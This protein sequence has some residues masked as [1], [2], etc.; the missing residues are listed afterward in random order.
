MKWLIFSVGL[1]IIT[2]QAHSQSLQTVPGHCG[3]YFKNMQ[4]LRKQ[5]AS[6]MKFYNF[7]PGENVASIGAQCATWEGA[8]A[9]YTDSIHFY[10]EDIDPV[11]LNEAQVS[12]SWS[13][14]STLN[15]K[16]ITSTRKI[17]IGSESKTNLPEHY[18]DKILIINSFHEFS[19]QQG[20]LADIAG[21]LRPGGIL[22]LDETLAE[23]SGE[24][25]VQCNKRIYTGD[26][27][28]SLFKGY[29]FSYISGLDM[30]FRS[31]KIVRKI[32]AFK[33]STA[34]ES[35]HLLIDTAFHFAN[36]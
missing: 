19:D 23:K 32:F 16:T 27:L 35:A 3:L 29:G 26:E 15:K 5:L 7:H 2:G 13:Y 33:L 36:R 8:F 22:Y 12:F 17:I 31:K 24:L 11:S 18:F 1:S 14:Y 30:H 10:L 25:H 28:I 9:T 20:M 4:V 34:S 21:K 6:Q